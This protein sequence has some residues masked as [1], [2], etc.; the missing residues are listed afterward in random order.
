MDQPLRILIVDD[1]ASQRSGLAAMVT[2]WGMTAVTAADGRE[3]LDKLSET[4]VDVI[5]T[6]LN[7]PGMDGFAVARQLRQDEQTRNIVI[8]AFTAQ[9][10]DIIHVQAIAAG[11]DGYC[12]KGP[13]LDSLLRLLE[14]IAQVPC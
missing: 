8:V 13:P 1:E 3:A 5:V 7:M 9:D 2:A 4:D 11:F 10:E 14:Q 12:Q 6:D